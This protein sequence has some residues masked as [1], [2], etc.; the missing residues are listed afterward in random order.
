MVRKP[1]CL[2]KWLTTHSWCKTKHPPFKRGMFDLQILFGV[3]YGTSL[4]DDRN[5]DLAGILHAFLDLFG[6]VS[7]QAGGSKIIDLFRTNDNAH[8]AS[9]LDGVALRNAFEGICDLL[10]RAQPLDILLQVLAPG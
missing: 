3:I 6:H 1:P 8:F 5:L 2:T 10:K 4:A 9:S 7:C